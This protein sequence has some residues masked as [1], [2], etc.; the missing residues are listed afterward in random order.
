[1]NFTD[2]HDK[3]VQ[4]DTGL[5]KQREFDGWLEDNNAKRQS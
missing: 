2:L 5:I 4:F 1:M 3:L